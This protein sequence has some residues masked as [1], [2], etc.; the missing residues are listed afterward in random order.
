MTVALLVTGCGML[1][2]CNDAEFLVCGD[3]GNTHNSPCYADRDGADVD[4]YGPCADEGEEDE[5]SECDLD[6]DPVCDENERT[7]AN[8]CL[9]DYY[10]SGFDYEGECAE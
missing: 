6:W 7:Y 8:E 4:Y 10:G 1:G 2:I 3:D 5:R 9:A